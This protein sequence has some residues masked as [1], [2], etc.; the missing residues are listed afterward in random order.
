VALKVGAKGEGGRRGM[1]AAGFCGPCVCWDVFELLWWR[2]LGLE[3]AGVGGVYGWYS[4]LVC[5]W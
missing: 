5:R 4:R 2:V 1:V 3:I